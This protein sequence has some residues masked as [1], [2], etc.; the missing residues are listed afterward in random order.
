MTGEG[1]GHIYSVRL[2]GH[3]TCWLCQCFSF[4]ICCDQ[5]EEWYHGDCVGISVGQ[6]KRMEREGKEYVCP[7]CVARMEDAKAEREINRYIF[8]T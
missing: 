5:C 8:C 1:C 3:V 7:V 4:M 2:E 6:G